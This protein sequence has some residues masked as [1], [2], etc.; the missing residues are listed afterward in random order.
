MN[1]KQKLYF[2][3]I[4]LDDARSIAPSGQCLLIDPTYN[5]NGKIR[6]VELVQLFTK[7]EKDEK[8]VC[9]LK[10]PQ[11]TNSFLDEYDPYD[12][13]DDGCWHIELSP[14][15]DN[16][17]SIIQQEPEYQKY[18]GKKPPVQTKLPT[19][20]K[21]LEKMWDLLQE[22]NLKRGITSVQDDI[23][24]PQLHHSKAKNNREAQ[25]ISDERLNMLRKLENE[26]H[27]IKD[28]RWPNDF[29]QYVYLKLDDRY[30]EVFSYYQAE[31]KKVA[32]EYQNTKVN[33]A[34]DPDLVYS[35]TY[36]ASREILL[37]NAFQLAKPNF[38]SENDLFFQFIY[39]N[40]NKKLPLSEIETQTGKLT[41]NI[42]KI[43]ENLGF[44]GDL[45]KVFFDASQTE[46]CF[47]NP[48]TKA[49][50]DKLG[51]KQIKL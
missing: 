48:I 3:L 14:T 17:Y 47:R 19:S 37:N 24:I 8:V 27:A 36:T 7:L 1:G 4:A 10:A 45:R 31:Y 43:I 32:E 50:L 22:I 12:H 41:K 29:T 15:F 35:I 9:V 38:N 49:D 28:V 33:P 20:R 16:Y 40:P 18:T 13:A 21:A 39:D 46:V 30:G 2:L 44:K 23:T 6:D 25:E 42:H 5:L 34:E 51:I 11:I 26:E